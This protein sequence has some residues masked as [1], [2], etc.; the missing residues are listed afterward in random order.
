MGALRKTRDLV[1]PFI[2]GPLEYRLRRGAGRLIPVRDASGPP[3][4]FHA[5]VWKTASQWVRLILS[6]PRL[7]RHSGHAPFIWAHLRDHPKALRQYQ[8]S[9]RTLLLTAYETPERVMALRQAPMR[10]VFI[11]RDPRALLASWITSTRYTHRPNAGVHAH[12]SAMAAMGE[13]DALAYAARAFVAEF[14]PV[15][16]GWR[17]TGPGTLA[18]RFEDLTGP[19]SLSHWQGLLAH[20]GMAVPGQVLERVLSTYRIEALAPPRP[21]AAETDKYAL[22]GVRPWTAILEARAHLTALEPL[23][24][25]ADAYG[26]PNEGSV[27]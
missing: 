13:T 22:R 26:Y 4:L 11:M 3:H 24:G 7:L 9:R 25:W 18:I 2:D 6:D 1:R 27:A 16:E 10:G 12:R 23:F 21:Q 17:R 8:A 20:L 14:G 15:L 19:D 5:C